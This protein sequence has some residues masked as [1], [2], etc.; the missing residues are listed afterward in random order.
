MPNY[1]IPNAPD[2]EL[3]TP[4]AADKVAIWDNAN[5]LQKYITLS[6][7]AK[8]TLTLTPTD[9]N[10]IVGDGAAWVAESGATARTSLGV[11]TADTV[12]V[13]NL[14][15]SGDN[16]LLDSAGNKLIAFTSTA[17]AVNSVGINNDETGEDPSI[18]ATGTDTDVGLGFIVKGAGE[19]GFVSQDTAATGVVT[20]FAHLSGSPAVNDIFSQFNFQGF[21]SIFTPTT[22]GRI[23]FVCDNLTSGSETGHFDFMAAGSG[24]NTQAFRVEFDGTNGIVS[25]GDGADAGILSSLGD[26]DLKLKSG[27]STTG[28]ITI[29]DGANGD[30]QL[31]PNGSGAVD[32]QGVIELESYTVAGVPTASNFTQGMI[33]VSDETGGAVPAFSD[34]TNWRRCTDRAIVS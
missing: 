34:G 1:T 22:Y 13:A 15:L 33:Y 23:N 17:S 5:S 24:T 25:V 8:G 2:G 32:V 14:K 31:A 11:G 10:F 28:S 3:T 21:N 9:G 30:I 29:V 4:L 19:F 27:N 6:N 26:F 16:S 12:E 20:S 7:L 18:F